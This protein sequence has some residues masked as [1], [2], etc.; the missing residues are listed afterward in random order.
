M[1]PKNTRAKILRNVESSRIG[2]SI[3]IT[4]RCS[5]SLVFRFAFDVSSKTSHRLRQLGGLRVLRGVVRGVAEEART[6]GFASLG[7]P[8]F[9]L[10]AFPF[11]R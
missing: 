9:A 5:N 1:D 10:V 4:V 3:L 7:F 2:G 11:A 8:R 6:R